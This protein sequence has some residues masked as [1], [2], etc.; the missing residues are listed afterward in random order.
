MIGLKSNFVVLVF[1]S[2]PRRGRWGGRGS[3]VVILGEFLLF[4]G[5]SVSQ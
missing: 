2:V 1:F 3:W 5:V 4:H